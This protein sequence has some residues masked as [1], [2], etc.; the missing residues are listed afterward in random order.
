MFI[1]TE[2]AMRPASDKRQ[3]FY[4]QQRIGELHKPTCVLVCKKVRVRMIVEYEVEVPNCW[5]KDL[6]EFHRNDSSWCADNAI[7]ELSAMSSETSCIC[8]STRFEYV[9]DTSGAYASE[10][11]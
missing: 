4:C 5:D 8:C 9:E 7:S 10:S 6:V 3:C 2:K 1:V 11:A